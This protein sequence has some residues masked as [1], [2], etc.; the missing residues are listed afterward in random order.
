MQGFA[1]RKLNFHIGAKSFSWSLPVFLCSVLTFATLALFF[2]FVDLKPRV[3][4]AF[5]FSSDDPQFKADKI[6]S[7]IFPQ[8]P[9]I[10]IGVKGEI[11]SKAYAEKIE[12]LSSSLASLPEVFAV[13]SLTRGPEGLKDAFS[14]PLWKRVLISEDGQSTFISVFVKEASTEAVVPKIEKIREEWSRPGSEIII[15]GAPYIVELIRRNLFRDL[16]IFSLAVFA[17]FS[18]VLVAI[19]RSPR[20]LWGAFIACANA[21]TVTLLLSRLLHIPIGPL[22]ANLSTM[23]F[24][25]TLSPTVFLTFNW[26]YL[27]EREGEGGGET[28]RRA[29]QMTLQPSFWSMA[30]TLVGFLSLLFVQAT[31]LRQLGISG[32]IGTFVAFVSAYT[33]YP[34]FLEIE[35][36]VLIARKKTVPVDSGKTRPFFAKRKNGIAALLVCLIFVSA[37]GLFQL[38]TDPNLLSYFKKGS[39]LRQGLEYI[40]QNGGSSPLKLVVVDPNKAPFDTGESYKR[41][42]Q[43]HETLEKEPSVG[44]VVSLPIILAE[45][46]SSPL[47]FFLSTGWLLN[48]MESPRF[49]EIAKYFVTKDR[50]KTLFLLR[51]RESIRKT[52]RLEIIDH[53]KEMTEEQGFGLALVGGA[54]ALQ[55]KMS[56]L[57]ASSLVSGI[58]LL[59]GLF[60]AMGWLLSRS[61]QITVALLTSLAVI[62]VTLLGLLGSLQIPLDI[63]STPAANL[64]IGMGVDA[65]IYLIVFARR[66]SEEK[67]TAW[68]VWSQA[69]SRLWRPIGTSLLLICSGFGIFLLSSFPPTQ[70][71]GFC[72]VFG[73]LTAASAAL[74]LFPWLASI[75]IPRKVSSNVD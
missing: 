19:F 61:R 54:Y 44:N 18:L 26:K 39:E 3:D 30:T 29:V 34:W 73:S 25:L 74:F 53:I 4:E 69:C 16:Q 21:S 71:F 32:A 31:P 57:L 64:A 67:K 75:P 15:S 51:M 68:E 42:W 20:I 72:V 48:I 12:K 52:S 38:N 66:F 50:D 23:V 22:T 8:P 63:I 37:F 27:M 1:R 2:L 60:V 62:P 59:L 35:E 47:S 58:L 28:V 17:V 55:G 5:F 56:K 70:R 36:P 6:I 9:Q 49:G 10:V 45:A 43:L 14:S 46:K 41:L 65:M 40:D 7:E 24:V 13:Q 11:H 33:L